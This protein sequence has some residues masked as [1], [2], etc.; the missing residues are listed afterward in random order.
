MLGLLVGGLVTSAKVI[1][2]V[3]VGST[4]LNGICLAKKFKDWTED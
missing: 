4:V 1:S 2:A 3:K